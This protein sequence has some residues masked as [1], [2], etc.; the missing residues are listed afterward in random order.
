MQPACQTARRAWL[1]SE[2][3]FLARH[4]SLRIYKNRIQSWSAAACGAGHE[5]CGPTCCPPRH[6]TRHSHSGARGVPRIRYPGGGARRAPR[7]G[8]PRA[9]ALGAG[10]VAGRRLH[11][12]CVLEAGEA[13]VAVLGGAIVTRRAETACGL[14]RALAWPRD[15]AKPRWTRG[16]SNIFC[17][18]RL[19]AAMRKIA[20]TTWAIEPAAQPFRAHRKSV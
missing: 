13:C 3:L 9:G 20:R 18:L 19:E 7:R 14:G 11:A 12:A 17:P 2:R 5:G 16:R 1:G 6:I 8:A 15:R 10:C 4:A